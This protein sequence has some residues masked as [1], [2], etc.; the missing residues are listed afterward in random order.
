MGVRGIV[1]WRDGCYLLGVCMD[2]KNLPA[3]C[4]R[5]RPMRLQLENESCMVTSLLA[6]CMCVLV[7]GD[8]VF[9]LMT[10][11]ISDCMHVRSVACRITCS[12]PT[13]IA[14]SA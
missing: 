4:T 9:R 13:S 7:E 10:K 6:W 14:H 11:Q 3:I 12:K 8:F 1:I 2:L 5:C